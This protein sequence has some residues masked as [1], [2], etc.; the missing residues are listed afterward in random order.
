MTQSKR[1]NGIILVTGPASSGKSQWAEQLAIA[2][3]MAVSYAATARV[4][5]EDEEWQLRI[6]QHQRRRPNSW[7]T[8]LVPVELGAAFQNTTASDCLLVDSLGTWVAN[9]LEEEETAWE[10]RVAGVLA[11]LRA[12][13]GVAILVAE[14]TGWGVVPAYRVGRQF[15]DRLGRLTRQTG[16]I[17]TTVYLVTGGYAL[18]LSALG[19]PLSE[20]L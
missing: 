16:A 13:S 14:E 17:A 2:T 20:E 3:G 19:E 10:E 1:D 15:R 6:E 11:S 8:L 9:L 4:D 12:V 7:K 5:P 18:N